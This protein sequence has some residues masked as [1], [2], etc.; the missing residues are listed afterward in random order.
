MSID[1]QEAGQIGAFVRENRKRQKVTQVQ[2][3][4]LANVGVR[5]VRDLEDGKPSL[6]FDKL[7]QVLH[8]LG[9]SVTLS[10]TDS[11]NEDA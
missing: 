9:V 4:Q 2:L 7:L 6:Q 3:S 11:A 5:F 10:I 8:A 1:L